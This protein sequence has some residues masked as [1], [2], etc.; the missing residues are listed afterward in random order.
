MTPLRWKP[1]L[2]SVIIL[3]LPLLFFHQL[4]FS[5]KILA[6]GDTYQYFY[7]Y[8]DARNQAFRA[9]ELPLWTPDLFMGVP[10]LA[11]PQ[12]G[13]YYPPNWLTTP[14]RAPTAITISILL[15]TALAAAGTCYLYR[16]VVSKRWL[17]GL[18]AGILY[19]F[20]GFI[21]NHVEQ[22][23]QLQ[24]LAWMPILFA[25]YHRLLNGEGRW[26]AGLLLAMAW[27]LQIFSGHTQ[28][29]FISGIGLGLY[30]LFLQR[31]AKRERHSSHKHT[32][33]A[34]YI[35][36]LLRQR[37]LLLVAAT[38]AAEP[39]AIAAVEPKQRLQRAGG[40]G[41]LAAAEYAGSRLPA[42]L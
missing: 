17:P 8:W 16:Q 4:A 30:G 15:H 1:I 33:G 7:P 11:N 9:G 10:L 23:N 35:G 24:G 12:L 3:I 14:F 27:A 6:R 13:A 40:D 19:A 31:V 36:S 41:I 21:G 34:S 28:T 26:R 18:V 22:I 42:E 32:S 25:L 38:I 29:V 2:C 20:G 37:S 5:G 39:G